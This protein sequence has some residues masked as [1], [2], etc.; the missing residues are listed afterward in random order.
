MII[1]FGRRKP[2]N[3]LEEFEAQTARYVEACRRNPELNRLR[4]EFDG[5]GLVEREQMLDEMDT[6]R[7][8]RRPPGR[9]ESARV[10]PM[11]KRRV[12]RGY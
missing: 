8:A 12:L 6:P 5:A 1:P 9:E 11:R 3:W 4:F 7:I 2:L 10:I